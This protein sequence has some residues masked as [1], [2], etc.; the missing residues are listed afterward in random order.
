[1]PAWKWQKLSWNYYITWM[2]IFGLKNKSEGG[3]CFLTKQHVWANNPL[4]PDLYDSSKPCNY[5]LPLD[6][7]NI[8]GSVII[9]CLPEGNFSWL[10]KDE[11]SKFNLFNYGVESNVG[12]FVECDLEYPVKIHDYTY[13]PPIIVLFTKTLRW[14]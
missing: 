2:I 4:I 13:S 6:V 14:F 3:I 5:I 7:V 8:Y 10:S 11:I 12:F 1:M 9:S